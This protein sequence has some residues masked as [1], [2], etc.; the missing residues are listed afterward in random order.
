VEDWWYELD[1]MYWLK[2]PIDGCETALGV[3][4]VES[5]GDMLCD[6]D[7]MDVAMFKAMYRIALALREPLARIDPRPDLQAISLS[8]GLQQQLV[9]FGIFNDVFNIAVDDHNDARMPFDAGEVLMGHVDRA[10]LKIPVFTSLFRRSR[11]AKDCSICLESFQEIDVESQE[12]WT[13]ACDGY[14]GTWMSEVL[15]FPTPE[16]L[17]CDHDMN[18]CKECLRRHLDSQLEQHGRNARGRLTCPICNR[19]LSEP[20]LRCLGSAEAVQRYVISV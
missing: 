2:C 8:I 10:N 13:Q 3:D 4:S 7:D 1:A 14:Q 9:A 17:H 16:A 19:V 5:L 6:F 18:V 11:T 15:S 20:E 12:R